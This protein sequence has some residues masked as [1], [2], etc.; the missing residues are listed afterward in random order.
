MKPL[1]IKKIIIKSFCLPAKNF[2][3][4]I[5]IIAVPYVII[6]PF[7][8]Y[9]VYYD[10]FVLSM[11]EVEGFFAYM[12]GSLRSNIV[13]Y[14]FI[15]PITSCLLANWHRYVFF[16]GNKPWTYRPLDFSKYTLKFIWKIILVFLVFVI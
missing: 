16:D 14:L 5:N 6:L 4:F 9:T 10:D 3:N 13:H 7:Y 12:K 1:P 15:F 2:N 8:L 11:F